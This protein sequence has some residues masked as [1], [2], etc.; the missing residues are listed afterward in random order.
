M[1]EI[2]LVYAEN[3]SF[4]QRVDLFLAPLEKHVRDISVD[5]ERNLQG[6]KYF[7]YG[8]SGCSGKGKRN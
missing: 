2:R 6:A 4:N 7:N 8:S 5:M 3:I 1:N